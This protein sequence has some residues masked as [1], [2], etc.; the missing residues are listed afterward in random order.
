MNER[1]REAALPRWIPIAA[2][3][4]IMLFS[5]LWAAIRPEAPQDPPTSGE[6]TTHTSD[7][8]SVGQDQHGEVDQDKGGGDEAGV[9]PGTTPTL[10]PNIP[11]CDWHDLPATALDTIADIEEGGPYEFSRDGL[12]FENREGLLPDSDHGYYHEYTVITP[13]AQDRG[14]RRIVT[15]GEDPAVADVPD[16][17]LYTA[18]HYASFCQVTGVD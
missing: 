16:W 17:W 14:A 18:D 7:P 15:G 10:A 3:V 11:T 9:S 2:L 8:S 4:A 13:G 1:Q 12:V 5:G 6:G